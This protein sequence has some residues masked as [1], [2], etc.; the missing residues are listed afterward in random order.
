MSFFMGR[1]LPF[2]FQFVEAADHV[3]NDERLLVLLPRIVELAATVSPSLP[4][5]ENP[6]KQTQTNSDA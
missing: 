1:L 6:S 5:D 4:L 2:S 3:E